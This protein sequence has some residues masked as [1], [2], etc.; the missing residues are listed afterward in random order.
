[1]LCKSEWGQDL[2]LISRRFCTFTSL[3]PLLQLLAKPPLGLNHL[4]QL[5]LGLPAGFLLLLLCSLCFSQPAV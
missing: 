2:G 1:M 3:H 4:R 5:P